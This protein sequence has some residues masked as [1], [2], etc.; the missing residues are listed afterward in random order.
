MYHFHLMMR[1]CWAFIVTRWVSDGTQLT[2]ILTKWLLVVPSLPGP[3]SM[4]GI[5]F[6]RCTILHCK[7]MGLLQNLK[8]LWYE[9][10]T[11]VF[12]FSPLISSTLW[13]FPDCFSLLE[14]CLGLHQHPFPQHHSDITTFYITQCISWSSDLGYGIYR[15]PNPKKPLDIALIFFFFVMGYMTQST[16]LYFGL[17]ALAC[18]SPRNILQRQQVLNLCKVDF[19]YSA[20]HV[21][22]AACKQSLAHPA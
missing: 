10:P 15:S 12:I 5:A 3:S 22:P 20:A 9:S 17:G 11:R 13:H 6:Q 8:G 16:A 19:P 7:D 18:P 21:W 2:V 14:G 1:V 4:M